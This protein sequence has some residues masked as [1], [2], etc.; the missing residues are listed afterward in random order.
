M[1]KMFIT[2]FVSTLGK[3]NIFKEVKD[4]VI[5]AQRLDISGK[6]KRLLVIDELKDVIQEFGMLMISV[7]LELAVLFITTK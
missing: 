3:T 5:A 4:V 6:E 1:R 7:L 2:L